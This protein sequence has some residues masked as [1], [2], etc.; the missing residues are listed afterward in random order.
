MPETQFQSPAA[1]HSPMRHGISALGMVPLVRADSEIVP[2][3]L[4]IGSG[5]SVTASE[6]SLDGDVPVAVITP[7]AWTA[8]AMSFL[9][10]WDGGVSFVEMFDD[11]GIEVAIPSASIPTAAQRAFALNPRLFLGATHL[12][13]RSGLSGA[14][15]NQAAARSLI[16][17][18]RP[19]A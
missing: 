7:A 2:L 3:T 4:S 9:V 18:T 17:V 19:I 10:S 6:P 11:Q 5:A 15:V 12:R 14:A 1:G 8:A 13:L 16:L